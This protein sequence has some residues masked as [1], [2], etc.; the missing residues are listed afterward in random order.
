MSNFDENITIVAGGEVAYEIT[1]DHLNVLS[2]SAPFDIQINGTGEFFEFANG[3]EFRPTDYKI[4]QIRIRN[5]SQTEVLKVRIFVGDDQII[6]NRLQSSS[7]TTITVD[8]FAPSDNSTIEDQSIQTN[9]VQQILTTDPNYTEVIIQN[10]SSETDV[11][12]GDQNVS[13]TRGVILK[14]GA[15]LVYSCAADIYAY[16]E[17]GSIIYLAVNPLKRVAIS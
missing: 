14:A 4:T 8:N 16:H 12:I 6:D 17:G 1:G 11:R 3:M 13:A 10:L 7:S 9:V 2:S 5:K 15:D